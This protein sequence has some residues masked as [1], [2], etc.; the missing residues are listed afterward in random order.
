MQ[1]LSNRYPYHKVSTHAQEIYMHSLLQI[2]EY[3][4]QLRSEIL[5]LIINRLVILDVNTPR[6]VIM[7]C[8][9]ERME[10]EDQFHMEGIDE[11]ISH[12]LPESEA[13]KVEKM[14][15]PLAHTLDVCMMKLFSYI[16][17]VTHR[18][19]DLDIEALKI[20]YVDLLHVFETTILTTWSSH[21]VQFVMFYLCGMK[22]SVADAFLDWLWLRKVSNP[23]A[24]PVIR[25]SAVAYIASLIARANFISIP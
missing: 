16:H 1:S 10:N 2:T 23:N 22:S 20:I 6:S 9:A 4:P 11:E 25:Q 12:K 8:E 17:R 24:A 18:E 13:Q 5:S 7:E 15:H 19:N 21:H 14:H 3:A